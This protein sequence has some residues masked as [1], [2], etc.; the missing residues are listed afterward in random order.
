[1]CRGQL[2]E[3]SLFEENEQPR[4]RR[5]REWRVSNYGLFRSRHGIPRVPS[6]WNFSYVRIYLA[7]LRVV[8]PFFTLCAHG[9]RCVAKERKGERVNE[10]KESKKRERK[11]GEERR[12]IQEEEEK[13]GEKEG[14]ATVCC[15]G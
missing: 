6:P 5:A 7:P 1:M 13:D 10:E 2:R 8:P 14:E 15:R 4:Q 11:R 3:T 12:E 9:G